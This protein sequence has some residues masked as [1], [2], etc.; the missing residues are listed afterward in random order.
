MKKVIRGAGIVLLVCA[1]I[2]FFAAGEMKDAA[3]GTYVS[4]GV[5]INGEF[6]QVGNTGYLGRNQKGVETAEM[7]Q[8]LAVVAGLFGAG[9]ITAS[10]FMKNEEKPEY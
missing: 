9:A 7:M 10:V 4:T 6:K 1:L 5:M 3:Q 8:V 2:L